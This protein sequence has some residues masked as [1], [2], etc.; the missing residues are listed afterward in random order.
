MED[1]GERKI[2]HSMII[3]MLILGL[4]GYYSVQKATQRLKHTEPEMNTAPFPYDTNG[5]LGEGLPASFELV[6]G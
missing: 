1:I 4:C 5:H 3:V 6:T 2:K